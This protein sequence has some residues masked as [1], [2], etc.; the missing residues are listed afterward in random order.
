MS[1]WTWVAIIIVL[2]SGIVAANFGKKK[3]E[4]KHTI[5]LIWFIIAVILFF[6]WWFTR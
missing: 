1:F 4:K 6:V 5:A 3:T 2:V